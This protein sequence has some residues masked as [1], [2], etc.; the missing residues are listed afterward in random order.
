LTW[1]S[2]SSTRRTRTGYLEWV[3][4]HPGH[5]RRGHARSATAALLA[6]LVEQGVSVVDVHSSA[7]AAPLYRQLG[8][9]D[10]G[11]VALRRRTTTP[12]D[13]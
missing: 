7:A 2:S 6:W 8:F 12:D 10:D 5:R 11:P 3:V 13:S 1:A 4:T 9:T